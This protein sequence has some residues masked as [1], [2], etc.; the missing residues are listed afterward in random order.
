MGWVIVINNADQCSWSFPKVNHPEYAMFMLMI[1][2]EHIWRL[3]KS[4][5]YPKS[6]KLLEQDLVLK[7]VTWGSPMT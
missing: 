1:E 5:G 3:P 6:S 2:A 4:F 7:P